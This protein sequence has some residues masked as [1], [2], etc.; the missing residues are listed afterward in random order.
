LGVGV[1]NERERRTIFGGLAV[2]TLTLGLDDDAR[3]TPIGLDGSDGAR[4]ALRF[5]GA[6]DGSL[7]PPCASSGPVTA[8]SLAVGGAATGAPHASINV[9]APSKPVVI[10]EGSIRTRVLERPCASQRER[11]NAELCRKAR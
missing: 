6:G 2:T 11:K 4:A 7:A 3:G 1:G 10:V 5:V 8:P 9:K